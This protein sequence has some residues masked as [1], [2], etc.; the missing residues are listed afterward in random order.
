MAIPTAYSATNPASHRISSPMVPDHIGAEA[1]G[2]Q[3]CIADPDSVSPIR[4]ADRRWRHSTH[5]GSR[6]RPGIPLR[7]PRG[8]HRPGPAG[9]PHSAA[10]HSP[11]LSVRRART[12][13]VAPGFPETGGHPPVGTLTTT[14]PLQTAWK[15][16]PFS[17]LVPESNQRQV[18][19]YGA[20]N[21]DSP[22]IMG[23]E[24]PEWHVAATLRERRW[25]L[26]T[27]TRTA[28]RR[29]KTD[30]V[31][32]LPAG[33]IRQ[34]KGWAGGRPFRRQALGEPGTCERPTRSSSAFP[35]GRLIA[36]DPFSRMD[37]R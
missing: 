2:P 29:R 16:V 35:I 18:K 3:A 11:L 5:G 34:P 37:D 28:V 14:T 12:T 8:G 36:Q 13:Q 20:G 15:M 1:P 4:S 10:Q 32:D 17:G 24:R 7:Q 21:D 33:A 31:G 19:R 25:N 26:E 23:E 6:D 30:Q 22:R 27:S 9:H